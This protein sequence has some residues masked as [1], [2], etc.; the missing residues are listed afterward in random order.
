MQATAPTYHVSATSP[1]PYFLGVGGAVPQ[2]AEGKNGLVFSVANGAAAAGPFGVMFD[3]GFLTDSHGNKNV[4]FTIGGVGGVGA[5][6]GQGVSRTSKN[7]TSDNFSGSSQGVMWTIFGVGIEA[8]GN[9]SD[10][11]RSIGDKYVGGGV[12]VG[13]GEIYGFYYSYTFISPAP[14]SDF[15]TRIGRHF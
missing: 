15:W 9:T 14:P 1:T 11:K 2:S 5:S 12:N 3:I 10:D 7:T 4:Y 6:F 13:V 8:Y